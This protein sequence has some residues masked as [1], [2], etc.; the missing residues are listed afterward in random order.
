MIAPSLHGYRPAWVRRDL[1]A[2]ATVWAVLVPES[3]ADA[4]IAGVPPVVGLYAAPGHQPAARPDCGVPLDPEGGVTLAVTSNTDGTRTAGYSGLASCG[5]VWCCPQCAA[6]IATRRADEL[7]KVMR[8]VDEA[9]GSAFLLTLTMRHARGDRLGLTKDERQ[10]LRQL[11]DKRAGYEAANAT[12][13]DFDEHQAE[14]DSIEEHSLRQRK[15]CW[16]VLS[17][18]FSQLA[19]CAVQHANEL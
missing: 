12:G 9:G 15:G 4:T 17:D 13:W 19:R 8:A 1:V 10:R 5:S 16:D 3:L 2:G 18:A 11:E 14:A 6:K 7:S